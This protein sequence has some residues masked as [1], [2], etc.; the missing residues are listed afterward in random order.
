MFVDSDELGMSPE[1]YREFCP[2]RE[3]G[4]TSNHEGGESIRASRGFPG[5]TVVNRLDYAH[6]DPA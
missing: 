4:M 3:Q 5:S 6:H 1:T 2:D